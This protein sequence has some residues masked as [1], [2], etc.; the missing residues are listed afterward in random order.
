MAL[1][2]GEGGEAEVVVLT[3]FPGGGGVREVDADDS[4]GTINE[5]AEGGRGRGE[6]YGWEGVRWGYIFGEGETYSR[7]YC[8][9]CG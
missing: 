7:I 9:L 5:G 1:P 4:V 3:G 8:S 2:D 6:A